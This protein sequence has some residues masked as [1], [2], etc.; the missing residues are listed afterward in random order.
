MVFRDEH[1]DG[2]VRLTG[3][4]AM[5][6]AG[7]SGSPGLPG[8][9]GAT[10][11]GLPGPEGP[12]GDV[13]PSGLDGLPGIAVVEHGTDPNVARP[14]VSVVLWVGSADPVHALDYDFRKAE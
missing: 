8:P 10:G 2:T 5:G 7:S 13:G 14:A 1:A 3:Q 9:T 4:I 11:A 12:Q 6:V